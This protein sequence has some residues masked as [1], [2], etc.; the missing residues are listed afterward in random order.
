MGTCNLMGVE[1]SA[2][3]K[4]PITLLCVLILELYEL[5]GNNT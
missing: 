5:C 2:P 4:T 1:H 3:I